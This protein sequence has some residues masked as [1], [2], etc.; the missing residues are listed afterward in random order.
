MKKTMFTLCAVM[1]GFY[2]SAQKLTEAQ[3]PAAVVKTFKAKYPAVQHATW[4]K[5][6][7]AYEANFE[8]NKAETSAI[9][10][11]NGKFMET[12]SEIAKSALPKAVADA[13]A[14][15]YAGYKIEETAKIEAKGLVTY[16]VE[17]EKGEKS[18][19]LIYDEK[20]KLL[21]TTPKEEEKDKKN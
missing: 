9:F 16:E 15:N 3:V 2:A 5:E 20:G 19:D 10:D 6:D 4:E 21:K 12:E 18:M 14:K 13:V 8:M 17:V 1:I 11:A 7:M